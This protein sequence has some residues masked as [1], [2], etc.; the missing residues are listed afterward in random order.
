MTAPVT[1][2]R[3]HGWRRRSSETKRLFHQGHVPFLIESGSGP[4]LVVERRLQ[5]TPDGACEGEA[6]RA[7]G[8]QD[9]GAAFTARVG[10]Q[11]F[12]HSNAHEAHQG[13]NTG[14]GSSRL[15]FNK[16][17]P[18]KNDRALSALARAEW[19]KEDSPPPVAFEIVSHDLGAEIYTTS[20]CF[21]LGC[22]Y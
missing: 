13:I 4:R 17:T 5:P 20:P 14:V 8:S 3:F 2:A 9:C 16:D 19:I 7:G 12:F 21:S 18:T 10:V 1:F 22:L 11:A 15:G 6:T